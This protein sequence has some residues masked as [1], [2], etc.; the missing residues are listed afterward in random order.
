MEGTLKL[1]VDQWLAWDRNPATRAAIESLAA[2]GDAVTL[3]RLLASRMEFG[4]AGL[5]AAMGPGNAQ[6][7]DLTIVQ[8]AQGL[9][10]YLRQQFS[11]DDLSKRGVVVGYDARHN[12]S[13]FARLSANVFLNAGIRT[14]LFRQIVCTPFVPFSV[15]RYKCVAGVVVTASHNPKEDN[16][17]KVYWENGAQIISPHDS[18]IAKSIEEHLEPLAS[19]WIET[20]GAEDPFDDVWG[21][22]FESLAA[23]VVRHKA[24]NAA[25]AL[26][27]TYTA[28][29]GV[30]T[31]FAVKSLAV[32]GVP[33]EN[34]VLVKEQIEPDPDFPTVPF[35]NPEEGKSALNLAMKA[36]DASGSTI[37]LA[38]DPDA[39]RLAVAEKDTIAG[40]W[41][42][43]TGNHL[44]A[45]LGW[46]AVEVTK[47]SGHDLSKCC[48]TSSAVSSMILRTM[49]KSE[50]F[51]FEETL[52]GFKWMGSR[53]RALQHAGYT[54]I[55]SFEEAIGFMVGSRVFD[56][57]GVTAAG[58]MV[59]LANACHRHQRTLSQQLEAIY[60]QYG[61]HYSFNSYV[62]S[63]DASKT[64]A[65][66]ETMRH[67]DN[68]G[69]H[70]AIGG[71][72]VVSVRD[73]TIGLDTSKPDKKATLPSSKASP[74]I[75][76]YFE[77]GVSL[78][79]RGSGT[80][81]K[82]K[83]YSELI[84]PKPNQQAEL[85]QF[86]NTAVEALVRNTLYGFARRSNL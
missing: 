40:T 80:E 50:G 18:G 60:Q 65:M 5:R 36:A 7:N 52:T 71:V 85:E 68:G 19:S 2:K 66:F 41:R 58:V 34:I 9:A 84:T 56:K 27:F 31:Q 86:V 20:S 64:S 35:P 82:I 12:S 62:V 72:R 74:M 43:F 30:G 42:V 44:G 57:D 77:N 45:L 8:T 47:A 54:P 23:E 17:Y 59:E 32:F 25:S 10:S 69:Y 16:G 29:H 48:M 38:N 26:K 78:T 51:H 11:E 13:R 76:Y 83:W 33:S 37:I 55:F 75:T 73:L 61:Y 24:L 22:Y 67:L 49:S 81:P 46:W 21:A 63:K 53:S 28:M 3:R 70:R 14:R 1:F 39:D 15:L 6:M 4:T 79:I